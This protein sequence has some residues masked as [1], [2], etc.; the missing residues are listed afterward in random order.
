MTPLSIFARA[1]ALVGGAM[2]VIRRMQDGE[3]KPAFGA[4]PSIPP[5][6][7]QGKVPT[8]K[9]PTAQGWTG[10]QTPI[11]AA[12]L[13]VNAFATGLEHPRWVEVLPNGDVLVAEA[14]SIPG[15]IKSIFGYAMRATMARAGALGRSPN[16][17]TRLR[18]ADGDGVAEST[19]GFP[20]R[21]EPALRHGPE[22]RDILRRQHRWDRRLSLRGRNGRGHRP[23]PQAGRLQARRPLDAQP[24]AEPRRHEALCRRRIAD[25]ISPTTA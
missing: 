12:G 6:K 23:R 3:P 2:V 25:A 19:D 10:N 14:M 15:P 22:G 7:P 18:D 17:I 8:L 9:M 16:N 5:A 1:V 20:G 21:I 11:A 4:A 13:K 24:A